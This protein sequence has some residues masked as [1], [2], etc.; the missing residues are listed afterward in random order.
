MYWVEATTKSLA[1]SQEEEE[2]ERERERGE[3]ERKESSY[4]EGR[5]SLLRKPGSK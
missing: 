4:I 1:G 5:C 3:R 2:R